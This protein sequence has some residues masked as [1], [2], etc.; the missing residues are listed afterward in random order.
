MAKAIKRIS[1]RIGTAARK[2][3]LGCDRA[4]SMLSSLA[5]AAMKPVVE[6]YGAEAVIAPALANNPF[7][8]RSLGL[9]VSEAERL[10][11]CLRNGTWVFVPENP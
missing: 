7:Y 4:F 3:N 8:K 1:K 10:S 11:P 2:Q 5:Y 9:D 6:R